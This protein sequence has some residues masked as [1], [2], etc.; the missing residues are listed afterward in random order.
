MVDKY[1][2]GLGLW[3]EKTEYVFL[4]NRIKISTCKLYGHN[5]L[6]TEGEG[7]GCLNQEIPRMRVLP[8]NGGSESRAWRGRK[9]FIIVG[10]WKVWVRLERAQ[11]R[12]GRNKVDPKE[13]VG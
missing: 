7:E 9:C 2:F 13:G 3:S 8:G 12:V 11:G 1:L 5:F 10:K 6:G 4:G